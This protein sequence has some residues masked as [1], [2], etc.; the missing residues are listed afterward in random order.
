M[1]LVG[2]IRWTT[3]L[4]CID[5]FVF[6]FGFVDL[7]D[8]HGL[9]STACNLSSQLFSHTSRHTISKL[10]TVE[11]SIEESLEYVLGKHG[12]H[13]R[14]LHT[15]ATTSENFDS[16]STSVSSHYMTA[17]WSSFT[18]LVRFGDL[19]LAIDAACS[20]TDLGLNH[21]PSPG[22]TLRIL[23]TSVATSPQVH[24]IRAA[25]IAALNC[26]TS[27]KLFTKI[28]VMLPSNFSSLATSLNSTTLSIARQDCRVAL[29]PKRS[30]HPGTRASL[31][32]LWG[33]NVFLHPLCPWFFVTCSVLTRWRNSLLL[34]GPFPSRF[35][36]LPSPL[37]STERA[38]LR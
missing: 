3:L 37:L 33:M 11:W 25:A 31:W 2:P 15:V 12:S 13:C 26:W 7:P 16:C 38:R 29:H 34:T 32:G 8:V 4:H 27:Q 1:F 23:L 9:S 10:F 24:V 18:F 30:D 14:C 22:L 35:G 19:S 21:C 36:A 28:S 17:T 5:I 6:T 20:T